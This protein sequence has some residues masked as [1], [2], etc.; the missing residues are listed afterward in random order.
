MAG[1]LRRR[2]MSCRV[3]KGPLPGYRRCVGIM[4]LD[5]ANRVFVGQRHDTR[6]E[7]W[8]MPQGGIDKGENA[9][10]AARRELQEEVGTNRADL[11]KE[12]ALWRSYDLPPEIARRLWRVVAEDTVV[13][14]LAIKRIIAIAAGQVV[15]PRTPAQVVVARSAKQLSIAGQHQIE[16]VPHLLPFAFRQFL[17]RLGGCSLIVIVTHG[18]NSGTCR[19]RTKNTGK[20]Q[21]VT[22]L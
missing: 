5:R 16:K 8:Q 19:N 1:P 12:S 20:N 11:L 10:D 4:L 14:A 21:H 3:S 15:A 6:A 7:A 13:V 9:L 18:P 22:P 2:R 17:R